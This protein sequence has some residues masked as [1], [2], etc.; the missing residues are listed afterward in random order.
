MVQSRY[1]PLCIVSKEERLDDRQGCA[2][3][4][5]LV[6]RLHLWAAGLGRMSLL[7]IYWEQPQEALPLLQETRQ[8]T[9]QSVGIRCWLA[10]VEAEIYAH[11][12]DAN[13]CDEALGIAKALAAREPLGE[14]YYA[15]GFNPSRLAGYEGACFVRLHRPERALKQ[16]SLIGSSSI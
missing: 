16:R 10:A 15:T 1:E 9:I 3:S 7:L 5:S 13:A 11:L 12:D 8:L 6:S 2:R 4:L 14:D